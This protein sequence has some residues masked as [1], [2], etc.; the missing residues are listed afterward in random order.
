MNRAAAVRPPGPV[1]VE[2]AMQASTNLNTPKPGPGTWRKVDVLHAMDIF[3]T[4]VVYEWHGADGRRLVRSEET[5][6]L[7][8]GKNAKRQPQT[9]VTLRNEEGSWALHERVAILSPARAAGAA[10]PRKRFDEHGRKTRR[11]PARAR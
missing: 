7:G 6:A 11:R 10:P 2:E 3:Q 5:L 4:N 9:S 8:G 1:T